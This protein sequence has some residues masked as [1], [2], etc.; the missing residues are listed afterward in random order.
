MLPC[1]HR[2][3]PGARHLFQAHPRTLHPARTGISLPSRSKGSSPS[4]GTVPWLDR[5]SIVPAV[6]GLMTLVCHPRCRMLLPAGQPRSRPSP[7]AVLLRDRWRC[8]RL[9]RQHAGPGATATRRFMA[10]L[11]TSSLPA[12]HS[13]GSEG[14][15]LPGPAPGAPGEMQMMLSPASSAHARILQLGMSRA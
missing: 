2:A 1:L 10:E 14:W 7:E 13:Y 6:P 3:L 15:D 4:P 8:A 12:G 9:Q 11:I 5:K